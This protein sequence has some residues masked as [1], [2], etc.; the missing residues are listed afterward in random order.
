M[1]APL[2]PRPATGR[3]AR[4]PRKSMQTT[5]TFQPRGSATTFSGTS[6]LA[7][8]STYWRCRNDARQCGPAASC[9]C[10]LDKPSCPAGAWT[11]RC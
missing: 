1:V 3:P 11:A 9:C 4:H 8:V 2:V 5:K 10:A 6:K 7:S